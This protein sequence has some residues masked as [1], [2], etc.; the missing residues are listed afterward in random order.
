MKNTKIKRNNGTESIQNGQMSNT[1]KHKTESA[2]EDE[3]LVNRCRQ[4]NM[5]AFGQLIEKYQDRLFNGILKIVNNYDDA[6]ELTQEAFVRSL[7]NIGKFRGQ[8]GFYTWLF[9]IGINLA[10]NHHRRHKSIPFSALQNRQ[11]TDGTQAQGLAEMIEDTSK[12]AEQQLVLSEDHDQILNTLATLDN[13]SRA[14]VVLR[15][16]EGLNYA[17][18]ARVLDIPAGTVKSRLARARSAIRVALTK[19]NGVRKN[20]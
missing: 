8:S 5:P 17:Q 13:N 3:R 1:S 2:L 10:I 20:A 14:V 9:R 4:G 19:D 7:K 16:I 11:N 15:D 12:T 18:I 6:Q